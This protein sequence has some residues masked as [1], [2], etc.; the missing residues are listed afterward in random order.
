MAVRVG[1][2]R[3]DWPEAMHQLRAFLRSR[4]QAGKLLAV[5]PGRRYVG[6]AISSPEIGALP[7]G[8]LERLKGTPGTAFRWRLRRAPP[9]SSAARQFPTHIAAL[10]SVLEQEQ[11]TGIVY[12]MP[13]HADGSSSPES[14]QAEA[15]ARRLQA[16]AQ[17]LHVPTLLWDESWTTR[18]ALG[19]GRP[20]RA[21]DAVWSHAAAA[22][23]IL[24]E[25]LEA[26][27]AH[28]LSR[29]P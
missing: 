12:G 9:F 3:Q 6:L 22:G 28:D 20:P 5:D 21:R 15:E 24:Q 23:I 8:L 29:N 27:R 11:V 26:M 7:Y 25:V 13:Y 17:K 2:S 19:S 18:E 10:V 16:A 1:T 4:P 14:R